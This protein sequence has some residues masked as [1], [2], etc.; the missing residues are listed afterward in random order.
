[1]R[2]EFAS[3]SA[4][5]ALNPAA[6]SGRLVNLYREPLVPGG[7]G[8]F[9]LR[10][11]PGMQTVAELDVALMR[12]LMPFGADLLAVCG[13]N[14]YRITSTGHSLIGAVGS[15]VESG[16][17]ENTG[18]AT[19]VAAGDYWTWDGTTLQSVDPGFPVASVA[20]IGGYTVVTELKGRRFAWS[21]LA[22]PTTFSGLDFA[23]A[24]INN[25]PIIRAVVLKDTLLLFKKSGVEAWAVSGAAGPDAF[26]RISGA[27]EET[28][29]RSYALVTTFPNG[30]AYVGSDG[31]VHIY[32][33]GLRPISTPPVEVALSQY[34]PEAL[35]YYEVR[36]HMML[37]LT[38]KEAPAW[39]YD[40]ATGEW[41]ERSEDGGPWSVVAITKWNGRWMTGANTGRVSRLYDVCRDNGAP[42]IRKAVSVPMV[43]PQPMRISSIAV[44][45]RVGM[46]RQDD[47][48][49]YLDDGDVVLSPGSTFVLGSYADD[50]PAKIG[51]RVSRDG[52]AFGSE[53]VRSLGEIGA[54]QTW[55][56]FRNL[57]VFRRMGAFELTLS[58]ARDIPVL[59]TAEVK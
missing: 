27:M 58:S 5:D 46:D 17:A 50:S 1:M 19:I 4:R 38:F 3:Q 47:T 40:I 15:S 54:Y 39:C 33:G 13:G 37:C 23:S 30:V 42:L 53:K 35:T 31:K 56:S 10:S 25:D 12:G 21:A 43:V 7:Q 6:N 20:Y 18:Y 22:D 14:L 52:V 9:Q 44:F 51:L 36:G 41:H 57:G 34:T 29:L 8:A 55:V 48:A 28:G 2:V 24:E 26:V 32:A 16:I 49:T 45:P 59:S 11:V